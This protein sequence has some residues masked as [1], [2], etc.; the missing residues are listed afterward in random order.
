MDGCIFALGV[1]RQALAL[2]EAVTEGLGVQGL[3]LK[4]NIEVMI[5]LG[6]WC[7]YH[8]HNKEPP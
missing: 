5:R 2:L 8:S 6:F 3:G 1:C 4:P 7:I